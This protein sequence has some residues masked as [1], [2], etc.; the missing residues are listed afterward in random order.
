MIDFAETHVEFILEF[1]PV[2]FPL[3]LPKI[4][5]LDGA[6]EIELAE[7]QYPHRWYNVKNNEVWLKES[8]LQKHLVVEFILEFRPVLFPLDGFNDP[9]GRGIVL[10]R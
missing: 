7:I 9:F 2:L 1:R 4:M 8:E 10:I 3:R 6:W 5:D